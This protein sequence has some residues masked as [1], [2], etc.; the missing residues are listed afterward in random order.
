MLFLNTFQEFAHQRLFLN[1]I[2][3]ILKRER[4][5]ASNALAWVRPES[6]VEAVEQNRDD[7][8][9]FTLQVVNDHT[10]VLFEGQRTACW[11]YK[12]EVLNFLFQRS[13]KEILKALEVLSELR[14]A[15]LEFFQGEFMTRIFKTRTDQSASINC[16]ATLFE[17]CPALKKNNDFLE[18]VLSNPR[19]FLD[20]VKRVKEGKLIGVEIEQACLVLTRQYSSL[21]ERF[22][23]SSSVT[24]IGFFRMIQKSCL[25]QL[26][27]L[28]SLNTAN[29]YVNIFSE[30]LF[31]K[32][33]KKFIDTF[34]DD[35]MLAALCDMWSEENEPEMHRIICQC[36]CFEST[37]DFLSSLKESP[38]AM[39]SLLSCEQFTQE[40]QYR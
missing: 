14:R 2:S 39:I 5:L 9:G 21:K 26:G 38:R 35:E 17:S 8:P 25:A 3:I 32:R 11:E 37:E 36:S 23:G 6:Q 4:V 40:P 18:S 27:E 7:L 13:G 34:F 15:N 33:D 12:P 16:L 30:I 22:R 19:D 28:T 10:E 29:T 31:H 1:V 20:I 24:P